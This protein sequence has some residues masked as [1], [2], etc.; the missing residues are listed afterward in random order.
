[1]NINWHAK[2]IWDEGEE[3]PRNGWRCFR[4]TFK[5]PQE[6]WDDAKFAVTADSRY[7]V[8]MN[9]QLLGRG[10]VR[11][12]PFEQSY[13]VYDVGRHLK[14]GQMNSIAVLV[15]HFGVSTFYYLR[16]RGGCLAQL[17][18]Q[19]RKDGRIAEVVGTDRTWKTACH[20]GQDPR[21]PRMSCQQAFAERI[22]ASQWN[23]SWV[24]PYYEDSDWSDATEIGSAGMEPWTRLV[25]RDIPLLTEETMYPSRVECLH[26]VKPVSW[27]A[28]IDMRNQMMPD[29]VDHANPVEYVGYIATIIQA[30]EK[31]KATLG[32]PMATNVFGPC[33][34]N[35]VKYEP[36]QF[37]GTIPERYLEVELQPGENWF[38]MDV[39]C[40]DHGNGFHIGI[41]C[42]LPFQL[43]SPVEAGEDDSPFVTI[44]PFD[45]TVI[46]DHQPYRAVSRNHEE[47]TEAG[48]ITS[49]REL[50][51]FS[52]WVK[53]IPKRLV[54]RDNILALCIWNKDRASMP[55]PVSL[56][57]AVIANAEPA[58][59]PLYEDGDTE[60]IVDFGREWSGYLAFE[61]DAPKGA[62]LDLYGFEYMRDGWIQHT[63][64]LDNTLRY[65]CKEGFQ[66]YT[67]P[68]RRGLRY[69]MVT[70][71]RASRPVRIY[72]IRMNQSNYPIAE[73]GRF[74][75][76]D[77]LLNDIWAISRHTTRLCME[78]TFVDCPAYEQVFWV[79]DSRNE[80]LVNYYLFG[81]DEIVKLCLRL[82]PGSKFQTPL[83]ADQVPS[84]W[85]SAIP[86]WTFFWA[87][88]CS[89][90]YRRTGDATFAQEM[91]PHVKY[92]LDHY[93]T[94][95][96]E[97]GLL[98]IRGWNLLDWA[99]IDQPEDGVV[100]HQNCFLAKALLMAAELAVTA[101][102]VEGG[103]VYADAAERLKLA[104]DRHLW[105][106]E[107]HAYLDCIHADGRPSGIF[108]MQTQV[109]A[110]LCDIAAGERAEQIEEYLVEPPEDFVQIGSPFMSFFYYEALSKI[111]RFQ[112][113]LDDMR[114][115]YGQMIE[116][117]A[118][119]CWEMYPDFTENRVNP[120]FL[121]RSHCHAWSAAPGYFLSAFVL[122]VRSVEPGWR[123]I[124]V[125]PQ[126]ASL[127]WARGS[128]PLPGEGRVDVSWK[129][130]DDGR[131]MRLQ[132]WAPRD[133]DVE[134]RLP[135]GMEGIVDHY[136]V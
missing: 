4:K 90:Y 45:Q 93:L 54:S 80:A 32:F 85:N 62:V 9:G 88:A 26:K 127:T 16:G 48:L 44:G 30:Q 125:S 121:T 82:V 74:Q 25:E 122:G 89:E 75:C 51:S 24:Q 28:A 81:A 106:D 102:D 83:Y 94:R 132:V 105:S 10:P 55:V 57:N 77:T 33:T 31:T 40:R 130:A 23:D 36:K 2:W 100:T 91:W 43:K 107:R 72:G 38:L 42:E 1:M 68:I 67:S 76:S 58:E 108:S 69:L 98:N 120:D 19:S 46:I 70:V 21:S 119:S 14:R 64:N 97:R 134:V 131:I 20:R 87:M 18:L 115:H 49:S 35:G 71:R 136:K 56:Q 112:K 84:G 123:K 118:S 6:G 135:E 59:I 110:Y 63:F 96:D 12:W 133:V 79:G 37:T 124:I 61:V 117:D 129:L 114:R 113:M 22:D 3:S 92:T 126:T 86:N 47:Y 29:S 111:G 103:S 53:P 99:P 52:R 17:Q 60:F 7:A 128:V 95:I 41:D 116:H 78:D 101:G 8:Y 66:S 73:I 11:S 13:D 34:V 15:M 65:E 109:V 50:K 104:I 5:A 27:T 39:T